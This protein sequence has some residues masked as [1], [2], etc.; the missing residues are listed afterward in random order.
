MQKTVALKWLASAIFIVLAYFSGRYVHQQ[1]IVHK[2][3]I[4]K[5]I[6]EGTGTTLLSKQRSINSSVVLIVEPGNSRISVSNAF[7][8]HNYSLDASITLKHTIDQHVYSVLND[9]SVTGL[10]AFMDDTGIIVPRV[11]SLLAIEVW[12]LDA[13]S[14]FINL[15]GSGEVM[16]SYQLHKKHSI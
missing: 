4:Y 9:R 3:Y 16:A 1:Y 6:W 5:G 10:E 15:I 13:E 7:N 12:R 11:P 14:L 2:E 8:G